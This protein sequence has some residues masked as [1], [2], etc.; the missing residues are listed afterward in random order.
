MWICISSKRKT[1]ALRLAAVRFAPSWSVPLRLCAVLWRRRAVLRLAAVR[2][3]PSWSVPLRLCAAVLWLCAAPLDTVQAGGVPAAPELD[4]EPGLTEQPVLRTDRYTLLRTGAR[5][6]QRAPLKTPVHIR[7]AEQEVRTVGEAIEALLQGSG[8]RIAYRSEENC[9]LLHGL[10]LSRPLPDSLRELGPVSVREGLRTLA[11]KAWQLEV[12]E[13]GRSL[14]F[15][16]HPEFY[17]EDIVAP[18]LQERGVRHADGPAERAIALVPFGVA[19]FR[20][21]GPAAQKQLDQAS[22]WLLQ[23]GAPALVEGHSHSRAAWAT[24]GQALRR[25]VTVARALEQAGVPAAQLQTSAVYS[26][27]NSRQ[28]QLLHG[29]RIVALSA[30]DGEEAELPPPALA[31]QDCRARFPQTE[32]R[33][34]TAVRFFNVEEGSLKRNVER[35]LQRFDMR[36]G[37]WGL[38]DGRYEYD[39]EIPHPYEIRA[40]SPDQAL[41]ELLDSYDI[42]PT[43]NT[44]DGS[45][46]FSAL[47]SP[48]RAK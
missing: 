5:A 19:E 13:L 3:A 37:R 26:N 14:Y 20:T 12:Q 33:D 6:E 22:E 18:H 40:E 48:R 42:Q 34:S 28:A 17:S 46:D 2:L 30:D 41:R 10:L 15:R 32:H 27:H 38:R 7:F 43:L 44:R 36:I 21:L 24:E 39:W 29:V 25:A 45:V 9:L 16:V 1:G 23:T 8:Y 47:Y 11:G 35:L 31:R 4:S